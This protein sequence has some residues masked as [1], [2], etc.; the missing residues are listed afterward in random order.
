[1]T[2]PKSFLCFDFHHGRYR[3]ITGAI[4]VTIECPTTLS[5]YPYHMLTPALLPLVESR[6]FKYHGRDDSL[7]LAL[8]RHISFGAPHLLNCEFK[9]LMATENFTHTLHSFFDGTDFPNWKFRME[10]YLDMEIS[11]V[12]PTQELDGNIIPWPRKDWTREHIQ[13]NALNRKA[14]GVIFSSLGREEQGRVQYY[15]TAQDMWRILENYREGT[16]Q[17]KNKKVKL[18]IGEYEGFKNKPNE[19]VTDTTNRL[20]SITTNLKK[21]EAHDLKKLRTDELIG[22]LLL[23]EMTYMKEIQELKKV[24]EEKTKGIA[25]KAKTIES[26]VE[27]EINVCVEEDDEEM[28][29]LSKKLREWRTR[30][31]SQ[32]QRYEQNGESSNFKRST[33]PKQDTPTPRRDVTCYGCGKP[34]HTRPECRQGAK[35]SFQKDKKGFITTW[36]DESECQSDEEYQEEARANLCF[37]ALVDESPSEVSNL[38]F[39]SWD[40]IG[41]ESHDNFSNIVVVKNVASASNAVNVENVL[42]DDSLVYEIDDECHD[43][44]NELTSKCSDYH[45]KIKL[46][47]REAY[48]AKIEM[49]NMKKKIQ[50]LKSS[51]ESIPKQDVNILLKENE[52]LKS[53]ILSLNNSISRFHK[54]KEY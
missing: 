51:L 39:L 7:C 43:M 13:A 1:M 16:V 42:V 8:K 33:T 17:V 12:A 5:E 11:Y 49:L 6:R 54:G 29:L 41:V 32:I 26:M 35:R 37:M 9:I 36:D 40:G 46:F 31:K 10:N 25:L 48:M 50:D 47:K 4:N 44:I 21:L 14:I 30:K 15:T 53:E 3:L 28:V 52:T 19:S 38:P 27:E 2:R 18:L 45:A 23:H 34:G 24:Q 20:L 22:N